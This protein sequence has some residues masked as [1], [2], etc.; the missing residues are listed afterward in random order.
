[1]RLTDESDGQ[2]LTDID[3]QTDTGLT[4]TDRETDRLLRE[5]D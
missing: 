3:R 4:E 1:M 2:R 5:L